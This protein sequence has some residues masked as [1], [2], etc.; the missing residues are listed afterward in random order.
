MGSPRRMLPPSSRHRRSDP[1]AL[2]PAPRTPPPAAAPAAEA[3]PPAQSLG[4][5]VA[6]GF[7]FGIGASI[8]RSLVDSVLGGFGGDAGGDLVGGAPP[9]DAPAPPLPPQEDHSGG[10]DGYGQHSFDDD[11][12]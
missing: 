12:E 11:E 5:V 4:S 10:A 6:E 2:T 1:H 8:A 7:A 9:G 3:P